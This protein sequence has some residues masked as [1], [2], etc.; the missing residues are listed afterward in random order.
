MLSYCII[1]MVYKNI[2]LFYYITWLGQFGVY[3]YIFYFYFFFFSYYFLYISYHSLSHSILKKWLFCFSWFFILSYNSTLYWWIVV[4]FKTLFWI[5]TFWYCIFLI[6]SP[7]QTV[8]LFTI[9]CRE[10]II[11]ILYKFDMSFDY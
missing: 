4:I 5:H 10:Q 8:S 2:M 6:S 7:S 11:H 3:Y 9:K 1:E